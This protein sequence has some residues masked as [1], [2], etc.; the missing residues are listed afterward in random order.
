MTMPPRRRAALCRIARTPCP[1]TSASSYGLYRSG[2]GH[3]KKAPHE[4]RSTCKAFRPSGKGAIGYLPEELF[5]VERNLIG[6]FARCQALYFTKGPRSGTLSDAALRLSA[7]SPVVIDVQGT[8][9]VLSVTSL[10][11]P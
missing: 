2:T 7:F 5:K 3:Q 9:R 10:L 6:R 4:V 11:A 8:Q 1:D